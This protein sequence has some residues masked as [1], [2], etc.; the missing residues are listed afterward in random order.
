[1][2]ASVPS[3]KKISSPDDEGQREL[4]SACAFS[5]PIDPLSIAIVGH[6]SV[7]RVPEEVP[8]AYQRGLTNDDDEPV[9]V[10]TPSRR[11]SFL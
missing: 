6:P 10:V 2:A 11:K 1:M 5:K 3:G 9:L 8:S 4:G 7:D